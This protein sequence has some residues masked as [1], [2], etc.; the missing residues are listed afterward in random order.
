M[1]GRIRTAARLAANAGRARFPL[2]V[3]AGVVI[4]LGAAKGLD[5]VAPPAHA[6]EDAELESRLVE[7]EDQLA[8]RRLFA[9]YGYFLDDRDLRAYADLFAEEGEW[10]GGFGRAQTPDGIYRMLSDAELSP[11]HSESGHLSVHVVTNPRID[12]DGDRASAWSKFTVIETA[13]DGSPR[14]RRVGH[15]R[16][17]LVR[18][19]DGWKFLQRVVYGD[20]PANDPLTADGEG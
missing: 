20:I 18:E 3:A 4:G 1:T 19:E 10:V 17:R 12:V 15:Y 8:I 2:G 11:N 9:D 6:A 14:V 7:A 13:E 16:D 5:Q